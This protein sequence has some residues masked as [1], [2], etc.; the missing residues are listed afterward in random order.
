MLV[1]ALF[2]AAAP[3]AGPP[4][5]TYDVGPVLR[6]GAGAGRLQSDLHFVG[7]G[8]GDNA[9]HTRIG[10]GSGTA[11]AGFVSLGQ[12]LN[13]WLEVELRTSFGL[14]SLDLELENGTRYET[15][16]RW[17]GLG[18]GL[19]LHPFAPEIVL[20]VS[21]L[22][23]RVSPNGGNNA[24][25]A[26]PPTGP[27]PLL[28]VHVGYEWTVANGL[29][30][31]AGLHGSLLAIRDAEDTRFVTAQSMVGLMLSTRADF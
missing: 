4:V 16:A 30:F 9:V 22:V 8:T 15:P 29:G 7:T 11:F 31:G 12:R 2:A 25:S 1:P 27:S 14:A 13:P 26:E 24:P 6:V 10:S 21:G 23:A 5:N 18:A 3:F 19:V 17:L 20:G 28:E